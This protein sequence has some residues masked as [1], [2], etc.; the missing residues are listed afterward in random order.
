METERFSV[1]ELLF[2]PSMVGLQQAGI[3]E[4]AWQSLQKLEEVQYYECN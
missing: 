3:A 4:A 1:P 2:A